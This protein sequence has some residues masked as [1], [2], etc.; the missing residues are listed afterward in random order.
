M[1]LAKDLLHP[2]PEEKRKH[3]KKHLVQSRNSYFMDV[4]CPGCRKITTVAA[5]LSSASLQEEKKFLPQEF[6]ANQKSGTLKSH[7][8]QGTH[9][10]NAYPFSVVWHRGWWHRTSRHTSDGEK[11]CC[12]LKPPDQ[13]NWQ[14]QA[15]GRRPRRSAAEL[16]TW[17]VAA[18]REQLGQWP[19]RDLLSDSEPW[20]TR[21]AHG[22]PARCELEGPCDRRCGAGVGVPR[23]S[24]CRAEEVVLVR[25]V[26]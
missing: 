18:Y 25:R 5:P 21:S 4:K 20:R 8:G 7:L 6:R 13:G 10:N 3:T 24:C 9:E 14:P 1:P 12:C 19:A 26:I 17:V 15:T 16:A 22:L 11:G 23:R 2:S